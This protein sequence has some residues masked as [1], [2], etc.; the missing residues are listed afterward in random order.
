MNARTSVLG[1]LV[2]T[3][4]TGSLVA[5]AA[6]RPTG[7]LVLAYDFELWRMPVPAAR[8]HRFSLPILAHDGQPALSP[9]GG[10]LAFT[11]T[12]IDGSSPQVM[13]RTLPDG[14]A[15]LVAKG[16]AP[17]FSADGAELAY[18][19][20]RGLEAT[21][22]DAGTVRV[23]TGD[24]RDR[25]P[26][27]SRQNVLAFSRGGDVMAMSPTGADLRRLVWST[28]ENVRVIRPAW[29]RDGRKLVVTLTGG[30]CAGARRSVRT[31]PEVQVPIALCSGFGAWSPDGSKLAAQSDRFL[32]ILSASGRR[33][34]SFCDPGRTP[35]G[36]VWAGGGPILQ[37]GKRAFRLARHC[38]HVP[39]T[40][41]PPGGGGPGGDDG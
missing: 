13:M 39:Q 19:T 9:A 16:R 6:A 41:G 10:R 29:S 30:D 22:L 11:R 26:A 5:P 21:D 32:R 36:L 27:W 4:A 1:A 25:D 18:G 34:D 7:T 33:L 3:I 40:G 23:L 8:V 28:R 31:A 20:E 12:D 24:S 2:L 15:T 14:N 38:S 17:T 37:S 35:R